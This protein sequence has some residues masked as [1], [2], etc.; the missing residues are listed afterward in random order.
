MVDSHLVMKGAA[1]GG[2]PSKS[3]LWVALLQQVCEM[4]AGSTIGPQ[5]WVTASSILVSPYV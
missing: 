5:N 4:V 1:M 3:E 2:P